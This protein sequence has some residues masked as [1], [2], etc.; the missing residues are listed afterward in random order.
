MLTFEEGAGIHGASGEQ[1]RWYCDGELI[2]TADV[3]YYLDDIQDV[4]NWLGRNH[5]S[6]LSTTNTSYDEFRLYDHAFDAAKVIT[7]RDA[8]PGASFGPPESNDDA[9]SI[10]DGQKVNAN[11]LS[12]DVGPFDSSIV[13]IVQVPTNGTDTPLSDGRILYEHDGAVAGNDSFTL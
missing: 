8:G 7:S 5:W 3:S 9:Y 4:N 1:V 12:N 2:T 13:K 10:H 11:V 6:A